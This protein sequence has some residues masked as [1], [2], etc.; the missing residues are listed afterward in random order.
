MWLSQENINNSV[1]RSK[2]AEELK[3]YIDKNIDDI[4]ALIFKHSVPYLNKVEYAFQFHVISN[5]FQLPCLL[6]RLFDL[7]NSQNTPPFQIIV[8]EMERE[9]QTTLYLDNC[10]SQ[11]PGFER[12][13]GAQE[14][15][16]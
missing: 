8:P 15:Q 5:V 11:T 13:R 14:G 9:R 12:S 2:F 3:A 1:L 4:H 7:L 10:I 16:D 6:F